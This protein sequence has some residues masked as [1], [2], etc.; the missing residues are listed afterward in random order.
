VLAVSPGHE[1]RGKKRIHKIAFLCNY[2]HA[3]IAAQFNIRHFGVFSNEIAGALDVL[4]TF[5]DPICHDE[6]IGQ[7]LFHHG[8]FAFRK[9]ETQA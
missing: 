4:T 7:W 3:P 5:G 9:A 8:V 6:Q 2:C 1:V